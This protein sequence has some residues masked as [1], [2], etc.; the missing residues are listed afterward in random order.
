MDRLTAAPT[1]VGNADLG[2]GDNN[3]SLVSGLTASSSSSDT[4]EGQGI[5]GRPDTPIEKDRH[6][7]L[8]RASRRIEVT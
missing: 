2:Q 7:L 5:M 1:A 8:L 3:A 6:E 4:D